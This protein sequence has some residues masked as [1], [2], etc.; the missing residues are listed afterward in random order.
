MKCFHHIDLDGHCAAA[1]VKKAHPEAELIPADYDIPF[2]FETIK[3]NEQVILV[4]YSLKPD[5]FRQLLEITQSVVWIDHHK[6]AI[7]AVQEAGLGDMLGSRKP[8]CPAG[9][10]LAWKYFFGDS[11][12]P[13]AVDLISD[14]DTWKFKFGETTKRFVAGLGAHD[15]K[16]NSELWLSLLASWNLAH[17]LDP[18]IDRICNDGDLLISARRESAERLLD[19]C[20]FEARLLNF[21][22]LRV[23][24]CNAPLKGSRIW[25]SLANESDSDVF[26]NFYMNSSMAWNVSLYSEKVDVGEIAKSF[27]GG[28]HKGAAGFTCKILPLEVVKCES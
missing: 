4:D 16:P 1:I 24:A 19:K 3:P 27:G 7:E 10:M 18:L 14:F 5:E 11:P 6:T 26:C 21:P 23:W 17:H 12:A 20:A 28:G 15:H 9:C 25:E 22:N 8:G 2:P 13:R